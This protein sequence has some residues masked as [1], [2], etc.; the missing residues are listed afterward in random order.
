MAEG[1]TASTLARPAGIYF[2]VRLGRLLGEGLTAF[3]GENVA[4]SRT[5]RVRSDLLLHVINLDI[6][7]FNSH[8]QGVLLERTNGDSNQLAY[9]FSQFSLRFLRSALLLTGITLLV[10]LEDWRVCLVV[11]GFVGTLAH[12]IFRLRTFSV[13]HNE[14]L[15]EAASQ[16]YGFIEEK[17]AALEDIEALGGITYSLRQMEE[18]LGK[19]VCHGRLSFSLG[20]L[21]WPT[22]TFITGL[23]AGVI[24]AW[25]GYLFLD[26]QM[27]L[28]TV[29]LLY[30]YMNLLLWPVEDLSH[31]MEELQKA[32]GSLVRIEELMQKESSIKYG[33]ISE[34][35]GSSEGIRFRK[36]SF[37]YADN[38]TAALK[39][40][41]FTIGSGRIL[42]VAGRTGSGKTTIGRLVS[43]MYDPSQGQILLN[44]HEIR[45]LSHEVLRRI[46]GVVTQKL[47]FLSGTLRNN[48][49]LFDDSY[50]DQ[51]IEGALDQ[52]HLLNWLASQPQGL[53]TVISSSSLDLSTGEVQRLALARIFIQDP[54]FVILD[55]AVS[56]LDP[57][58]EKEVEVSLLKLLQGRTGIVIAHRMRS[59]QKAD[60]LLILERGEI[61]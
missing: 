13:P 44:G 18:L 36:V 7:F 1:V 58:T 37:S 11:L 54:E 5:N 40:I 15:R 56:S 9:F 16:L 24:L 50:T 19:L 28:G 27:T 55:E 14:K 22:S 4:W 10:A 59:I 51:R 3:V 12:L 60:E 42:G 57:A 49:C 32:G 23:V 33:L 8:P 17:L 30:A 38:A 29:Y 48:L 47:Q 6:E 25:G 20:N 61:L 2:F 52:L 43:R 45:S 41:D 35:G 31:R 53:D 21:V 26:G 34:V 46:V 39:D